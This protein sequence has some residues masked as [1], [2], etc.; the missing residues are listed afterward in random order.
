MIKRALGFSV[1]V[2]WLF[3][4]PQNLIKPVENEDFAKYHPLLSEPGIRRAAKW[5]KK[6]PYLRGAKNV[7][8]E[9]TGFFC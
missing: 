7:K 4:M 3:A 8:N 9:V 5:S 6:N 1:K 2:T